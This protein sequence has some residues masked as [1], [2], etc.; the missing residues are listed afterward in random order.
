MN[1]ILLPFL[2]IAPSLFAQGGFNCKPVS[3]AI[4][5]NF[6][7]QKTT[8]GTATGD[9]RGGIGVNVISISPGQ[10][11]STVFKNQH[12]WVTETG[13]T[14]FLADAVATA[15]PAVGAL[16]AVIYDNGV[17]ITG[18]T[19]QFIGAT[20]TL[21]IYGAVDLSQ[22]QIVL[23]YAGQICRVPRP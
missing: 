9:L 23:R 4:S 16:Y 1:K 18:G 14:L 8:L 21:N 10:G 12:H 15:H 19:G 7:D 11:G 17:Q 22:G 20:G 5:T 3:G 6:I 2:L 13:D